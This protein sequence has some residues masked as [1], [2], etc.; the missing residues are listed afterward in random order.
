[1]QIFVSA[2]LCATLQL[3][4]PPKY[5]IFLL[6]R[7]FNVNFYNQQHYLFSHVNDILLKFSLSQIVPLFT[8]MSPT[9]SSS[10]IDLA[11]VS[12]A[13]LSPLQSCTTLPPLA[14]SDHLGVSVSINL[15]P[16]PHCDLPACGLD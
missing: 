14:S 7:D 1:M 5:S 11:L 13:S 12:E 8:H 16:I 6:L 4:Q 3:V 10:L 2:L 15:K 9:G